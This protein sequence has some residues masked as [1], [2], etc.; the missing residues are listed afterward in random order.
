MFRN[1]VRVVYRNLFRQKVYTAVNVLG[2]AI[3]LACFVLILLFIRDEFRYDAF[4]SKGHCMFRV[5]RESRMGGSDSR[6]SPGT[7]GGIARAMQNDFPE[8]EAATRVI[9]WRHWVRYKE[10]LFSVYFCLADATLLEVFDFQMVRGDIKEALGQPGSA[11]ASESAARLYFGVES[12]IGKVVTADSDK[13]GGDCT[14]TGVVKDMPRHARFQFDFL[15]SAPPAHAPVYFRDR[16]WQGWSPTNSWRPVHTYILLADGYSHKDLDRKLHDFM[17]RYMGVEIA[18]ANAYHLQTVNR[19]HLYSSVDFGLWSRGGIAYVY[20]LASIGTFLLLIACIKFMNLAT[21][22]S[23]NRAREIGMR[24]V[25]GAYRMQLV[26]QFL[27]ESVA[28]AVIALVIAWQVAELALPAFNSFAGK[29]LSLEIVD[30]PLL[31]IGL[32]ITALVVGLLT[33]ELPSLFF[34]AF[35]P[36]EV[37]KGSRPTTSSS[38]WLRKGLVL[39]Q[40]AVSIGLIAGTA[41]VYHQTQYMKGRDMGFNKDLMVNISIFFPDL[42]LTK[43]KEAV[44]RTFLKHANVLKATVCWPPIRLRTGSPRPSSA[45]PAGGPPVPVRSRPSDLPAANA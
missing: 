34:S 43:R 40:F 1:Y 36:A 24:K 13:M 10:K 6:F 28:F 11:L 2:L 32:L 22:R 3:G 21:A 20:Q 30:D 9:N 44:K 45:D 7:S 26:R 31:F 23:A 8:V 33:G 29:S 27:A 42:S 5:L 4:H 35:R 12:P 16:A 39:F 18:A 37:L 41:V 19:I 14:I 25:M 38:A 17:V 15:T